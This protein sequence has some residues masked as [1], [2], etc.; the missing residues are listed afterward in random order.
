MRFPLK[1]DKKSGW[2]VLP[3]I[4][5]EG[6]PGLKEFVRAVVKEMKKK[7]EI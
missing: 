4:S 1:K 3:W 2:S 7:G 5:P 6:I